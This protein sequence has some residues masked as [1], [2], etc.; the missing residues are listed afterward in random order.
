MYEVGICFRQ[1]RS[2]EHLNLNIDVRNHQ[3]ARFSFSSF[4]CFLLKSGLCFWNLWCPSVRTDSLA[5]RSCT[6]VRYSLHKCQMYFAFVSMISIL[7]GRKNLPSFLYMNPS[8][9]TLKAGYAE[10]FHLTLTPGC[11]LGVS[12]LIHSGTRQMPN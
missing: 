3:K 5:A 9:P 4:I 6:F 11:S 2:L 10:A 7:V 1:S 8:K 12:L